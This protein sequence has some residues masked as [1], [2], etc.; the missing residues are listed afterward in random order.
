[1]DLGNSIKTI[2]I[3]LAMHVAE[4]LTVKQQVTKVGKYH[5]TQ[6]FLMAEY[7]TLLGCIRVSISSNKVSK[8]M[9]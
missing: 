6:S 3:Q 8:D 7:S 4:F 1:M 5:S 9:R 2:L